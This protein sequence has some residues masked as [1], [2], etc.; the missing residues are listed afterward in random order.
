MRAYDVLVDVVTC[1][2]SF[3]LFQVS[4]TPSYNSQESS[5][6]NSLDALTSAGSNNPSAQRPSRDKITDVNLTP[7]SSPPES[8]FSFKS[9]SVN[10]QKKTDG[11]E[12]DQKSAPTTDEVFKPVKLR[13]NDWRKKNKKLSMTKLIMRR[14]VRRSNDLESPENSRTSQGDMDVSFLVKQALERGKDTA[15]KQAEKTAAQN[16]QETPTED[17]NKLLEMAM[18]WKQKN[19]DPSYKSE[20]GWDTGTVFDGSS[21]KA[22]QHSIDRDT[23]AT[24]EPSYGG[25][26]SMATSVLQSTRP[27]SVTDVPYVTRPRPTPKLIN[28]LMDAPTSVRQTNPAEYLKSDSAETEAELNLHNAESKTTESAKSDFEK[29]DVNL[30][31]ATTLSAIAESSKLYSKKAEMNMDLPATQSTTSESASSYSERAE[32]NTSLSATQPTTAESSKSDFEKAEMNANL[33]RSQWAGAE[34]TKSYSK[35]AEMKLNLPATQWATGDPGKLNSGKSDL[36]LNLN[37]YEP[38]NYFLSGQSG[39]G[40]PN[41]KLTLGTPES[42]SSVDP[43]ATPEDTAQET[44]KKGSSE[45]NRESPFPH[46]QPSVSGQERS[47][48]HGTSTIPDVNR[49]VHPKISASSGLRWHVALERRDTSD[50]GKDKHFKKKKKHKSDSTT[51]D[52]ADSGSPIIVGGIIGGIFMLMAIVT[53]FIQL[54]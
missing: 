24:S 52:P 16:P 27:T 31:F 32:M 36:N 28:L 25:L 22:S 53:C 23:E 46:D 15:L 54:W 45:N 6:E 29:P 8:D 21:S 42:S 2:N 13:T 1:H 37:S 33:P 7:S 34:S 19:R 30:D 40:E 10:N 35:E 48:Q 20:T 41:P 18:L 11:S 9:S 38:P 47:S 43:Q 26:E 17:K 44:T 4:G 14:A 39:P 3:A 49:N 51:K 5:T 50:N 12:D